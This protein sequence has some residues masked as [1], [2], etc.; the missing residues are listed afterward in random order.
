MRRERLRVQRREVLRPRDDVRGR[1]ELV[2]R[3]GGGDR[4]CA[5]SGTTRRFDS[6][7]GVLEDEAFRRRSAPTRLRG[8]QEQIGSGLPRATSC[9]PTAASKN[10]SISS[11]PSAN[12]MLSGS[13]AVAHA[14]RTPAVFAS[15]A[16]ALKPAISRK[17]GGT[18]RGRCLPSR[19]RTPAR[20][21]PTAGRKARASLRCPCGRQCGERSPRRR[22]SY[23]ATRQEDVPRPLVIAA[24]SR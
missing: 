4:D 12:A 24:S 7:R 23:A 18:A 9:A 11:P 5:H 19:A 3:N 14:R 15:R 21:R 8:E 1:A 16:N 20:R 22:S 10:A 13:P 17:S 6:K 2:H